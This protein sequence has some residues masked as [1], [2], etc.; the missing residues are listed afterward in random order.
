[1]MNAVTSYSLYVPLLMLS[2][3]SFAASFESVLCSNKYCR[4]FF[5]A[6]EL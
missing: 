3:I 2:K 1:V 6:S 5:M 4:I